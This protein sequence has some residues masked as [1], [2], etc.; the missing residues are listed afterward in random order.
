MNIE[1]SKLFFVVEMNKILND[2]IY[3]KNVIRRE[4]SLT[5]KC[6]KMQKGDWSIAVPSL[7]FLFSNNKCS[8]G[9]LLI[10]RVHVHTFKGDSSIRWNSEW[11][12]LFI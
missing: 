8:W 1:M 9:F 2:F 11:Y 7:S 10:I 12:K 6:V 3:L 5:Y 4:M